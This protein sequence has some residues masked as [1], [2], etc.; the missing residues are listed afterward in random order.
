MQ[1]PLPAD[2]RRSNNRITVQGNSSINYIMVDKYMAN[3]KS[4][5]PKKATRR[6]Q[7]V[8]A[9][10]K[11]FAD[12][13]SVQ[14]VIVRHRKKALRSA[15]IL[16]VIIICIIASMIVTLLFSV[17]IVD[18]P[19]FLVRKEKATIQTKNPIDILKTDLAEEAISADMFALYCMDYLIRYDSL[20]EKYK[21]PFSTSTIN[22]YFR[23]ILEVW[24]ILSL[25]TQQR[26]LEEIPKFRTFLQQE[27]SN[28]KPDAEHDRTN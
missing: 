25:R 2:V 10:A 16:A 4:K 3:V 21:T 9:M 14:K 8:D 13:N 15:K 17:N 12:H 7:V 27:Q 28:R 20:P 11:K 19:D 22:D 18:P 24:D 26:L 23:A 1:Y 5:T 6:Q